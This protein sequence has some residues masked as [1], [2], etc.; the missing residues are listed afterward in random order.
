MDAKRTGQT[1]RR[2][3]LAQ[4]AHPVDAHV[5]QRIFLARRAKGMS[6]KVLAGRL[7]ITFQQIQKYEK[8]KNRVS[9]SVLYGIMCALDVPATYFFEEMPNGFRPAPEANVLPMDL[10]AVEPLFTAQDLNLLHN[11]LGAPL[12]VRKAV[13]SL[14][15]I[16]AKVET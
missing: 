12:A 4:G 8:G 16:L 6:Q 2:T 13:R 9:A 11:Y 10:K 3:I 15:S 14:L 1:Q 5:G 7:G